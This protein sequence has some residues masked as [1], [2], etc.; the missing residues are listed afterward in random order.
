[1]PSTARAA[2]K[3]APRL[4]FKVKDLG[5][6]EWGRKEIDLAEKE[7]PGLMAVRK[8][9]AAKKPLKGQ[10][11]TGSLHMTIQTAVLVETLRDLGAEVRWASCNIFSTQ[12]HAAAAVA[13]SGTPVF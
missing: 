8:E 10:R 4:E 13:A 6:A 1:M 2:K 9:Y 7:M 5:L 3:A 11:I 12:D